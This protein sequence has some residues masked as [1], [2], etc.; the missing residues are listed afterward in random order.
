VGASFGAT[1]GG[2]SVDNVGQS[3]T[4]NSYALGLYGGRWYGPLGFDA[5]LTGAYNT[6]SSTR[7]IALSNTT[8]KG[9]TSGFGVGLSG[10]ARYRIPT[11]IATV[12]PQLGLEYTHS[13]LNGYTESGAGLADL[14]VAATAQDS[15]RTAAGAE[16]FRAFSDSEGYTVVPEFRAAWLHQF[17]DTTPTVRESFAAAPSAA[18]STTGIDVG[19]DAALLEAGLAFKAPATNLTFYAQY[20]ATLSSREIDHSIRGG[21]AFFW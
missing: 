13:H 15:F 12:E 2:V 3:G 6:A 16:V 5:E 20:A 4:A 7:F 10:A 21:F 17:L 11:P 19:R 18:F 8:A 9:D 1:S 14:N